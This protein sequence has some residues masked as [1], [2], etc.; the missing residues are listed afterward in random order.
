MSSGS[1]SAMAFWGSFGA[2]TM[3]GKK[4]KNN[5]FTCTKKM[6][7]RQRHSIDRLKHIELIK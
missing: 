5:Y 1:A 3:T 6:R 7:D 4:E 2:P